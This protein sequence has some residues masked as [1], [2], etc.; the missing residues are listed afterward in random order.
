MSEFEIAEGGR[1]K[2]AGGSVDMY[3]D[4]AEAMIVDGNSGALEAHESFMRLREDAPAELRA[5]FFPSVGP[6]LKQRLRGAGLYRFLRMDQGPG[7]NFTAFAVDDDIGSPQQAFEVATPVPHALLEESVK[8]SIADYPELGALALSV[9]AAYAKNNLGQTFGLMNQFVERAEISGVKLPDSAV[10]S[11]SG[12]FLINPVETGARLSADS[13]PVVQEAL[14][15]VRS[16]AAVARQHIRDGLPFRQAVELATHNPQEPEDTPDDLL[17]FQP[18]C[19]V[20]TDG[21]VAI[22]RI[23]FPDVG[24]FLSEIDRA[25]NKPLE[26]VVTIVEKLKEQVGAAIE[27]HIVT[28][29]VTIVVKDESL[30]SSTDMLEVNEAKALTKMLETI[31][32]KVSVLGVSQHDMIA[33]DT[34]MIILNPDVE[35]EAYAAFTEKVVKTDIPTFPDPLLKVFEHEAT[36]LPT[37]QVAGRHLEK[38]LNLVQ[39]KKIDKDNASRIHE[40]LFRMLERGKIPE[41]ADIL[42]AFVPGQKTPVPL[43]RY[44][45]HSFMQLSNAVEKSRKAG[46]DVSSI[47]L[48]SVPF[49]RE[50]AV[51]G[52]ANGK[53]L[54]AFRPMYVRSTS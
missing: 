8:E 50:T 15:S 28:S 22:E 43:F 1:V 33:G 37:F 48:R 2:M 5:A 53:R 38:L 44:S 40:E 13:Q 47:Y 31:G 32:F 35:S 23:N 36:T 17:Y 3:Y 18:D 12:F 11:R 52:D 6:E 21:N 30:E 16:H 46:I 9:T 10:G 29:H 27:R 26:Q 54:A 42:Y 24:F 51:F 25:N 14:A 20:D 41:D 19:F 7:G 49:N 45:L 4:A 34:S 39:P